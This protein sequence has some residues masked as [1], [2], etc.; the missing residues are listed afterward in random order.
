MMESLLS[1]PFWLLAWKR[2]IDSVRMKRLARLD[3]F[4]LHLRLEKERAVT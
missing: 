3:S 1:E 4:L 2:G